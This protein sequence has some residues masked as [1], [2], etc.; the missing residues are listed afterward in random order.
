M[1]KTYL[2]K[3]LFILISSTS[4]AQYRIGQW[5]DYL[6]YNTAPSVTKGNDRVYV[7]TGSCVFSYN[8]NDNSLDKVNKI[9]GLSDMGAKLVRFNSYNNTLI[10]SYSNSNLDVVKNGVITNF[11]D[12]LRKNITG[13]K[14]IFHISF[15][16]EKAYIAT[17]FG[18]VVFDTDKM[19]FK[20]TYIIGNNGSYLKVYDVAADSSK[21][22]AATETG[23]KQAD[24]N[25]NLN[26]FQNW[27]FVPGL[28]KKAFNCVARFQN[29][30]FANYSST[31]DTGVDYKDTLYYFNGNT[32][33]TIKK[34]HIAPGQTYQVKRL[35]V[36][37]SIQ[38]LLITDQWGIDVYNKNPIWDRAYQIGGNFLYYNA[39]GNWIFP[40]VK[41]AVFTPGLGSF[42]FCVAT[43]NCGLVKTTAFGG[44]EQILLDGPSTNLVSQVC[45]QD[46]KLAVAPVYLSEI[47]YNQY[48]RTGVYTFSNGSWNNITKYPLDSIYD[49]NCI[50]FRKNSTTNYFAGTWGNGLLEFRNDTLYKIYNEQN[51]SLKPATTTS[52]SVRI[53]GITTDTAGNVWVGNA[54]TSFVLSVMRPSGQW[55]G[56][57]FAA[58]APN[59]SLVGKI[60]IDKNNQKWI[61]LPGVG[62]LVYNDG[63]N[64]AQPNN[65]NTRKIT[66]AL[67][68]GGLPS[69]QVFS[70][71]E[72]KDG[73]IWIGCDKGVAVFYN[74]ESILSSSSGWDCQQII[75]DQ[76]GIAKIL[77]ETETVFDIVVDGN[78]RKWI[79]TKNGVYCLSADGQ[80]QIYHFTTENSPLFSNTVID[81]EYNGKTGDVFFATTE[82]LQSF[83]SDVIDSFEDFTDVYAYPNPV[84]PGYEGPI[85]IK[86]MIDKAVVKITDITGALV[87][88]TTAKG[89]QAI[90]YGKN[91]L[92]ERVSTGV[93]VVF[94]ATSNGEQKTVTKILLVN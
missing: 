67:N 80:N 81:L 62:F 89:G 45:I 61:Q 23:L 7:A 57:N 24:I 47:W 91:S 29:E 52:N 33:D 94:C 36:D 60:L 30:F 82:G 1:K 69:A 73:D 85:V 66:T 84:R 48:R 12:I 2:I 21:I 53:N 37:E 13:D 51:S 34:Y 42:T 76:N 75:I 64:Y 19:E 50:A 6:S 92:G 20:D 17:G 28:P 27:D 88:E 63:G 65:S 79:A 49:V 3:I 26:D 78:N 25:S 59:T 70:M 22:L 74:P 90:W 14:T 41:E 9:T 31:L 87:Y 44:Q 16:K 71:C 11:S 46:D 5:V 58:F 4:F 77:L 39:S 93:Y 55:T 68:G 8:W 56:L 15:Y 38:S 10:I 83:R 40:G 86:G 18:I 32:W 35:L 43:D 54:F 72:D